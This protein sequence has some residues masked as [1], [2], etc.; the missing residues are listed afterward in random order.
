MKTPIQ[1]PKEIIKDIAGEIDIG[2]I[3][4][5]T[6]DTLEVE[7]VMG[8]SYTASV[9]SR[10]NHIRIEPTESWQSFKIMEEFIETCIPDHDSIKNRL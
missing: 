1:Y 2:M 8:T 5:L 10:E 9:Q 6:T 7:S 3:C 4:L